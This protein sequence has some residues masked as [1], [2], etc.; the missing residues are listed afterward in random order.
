[1]S[2]LLLFFLALEL[3]AISLGAGA[4]FIFDSFF[5]L[6][7]KNH[8]LKDQEVKVL[9]RLN[10]ISIISIIV[11]FISTT[12]FHAMILENDLYMS[13]SPQ[14]IVLKIILYMII[15]VAILTLRRIHIPSLLRHQRQYIHLSDK[16][17]NHQDSLISTVTYSSMSWLLIIFIVAT[18]NYQD[19]AGGV[20]L[21]DNIWLFVVLYILGGFILSKINIF[22]KNRLIST[23]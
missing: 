2:L 8:H 22:I 7:L 1:M 21:F 4:S 18:S 6:S 20:M 16:F 19:P 10:N 9:S 17:K 5:I 15:F 11:A 3:T 13:I 14:L 23:G 12:L